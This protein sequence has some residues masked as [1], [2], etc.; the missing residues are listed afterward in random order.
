MT[1][2]L[3]YLDE[4][5]QLRNTLLR[6]HGSARTEL[7]TILKG[8]LKGIFRKL[9]PEDMREA[10]IAVSP[11]QGR[12]MDQLIIDHQCRHIVEFGTSFVISTL[13]LAAGAKM[14]GGKV[15]TTEI[16]HD[17]M[18]IAKKHFTEASVADVSIR[19]LAMLSQH[20]RMFR[21]E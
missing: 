16:L 19:D 11:G 6:L 12:R 14:T 8:L 4:N 10:F 18:A 13:Y 20:F 17:K 3:S 9:R 7:R 15:I 2:M 1:N 5:E 21:Q